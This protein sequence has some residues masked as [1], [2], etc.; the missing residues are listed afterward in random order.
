MAK[1]QAM[2]IQDSLLN[3]VRKEGTEVKIALIDG[4]SLMG[5]VRGFDNFTVVVQSKTNQHLLYKHAIAQII[6]RRPGARREEPEG[7][8][9]QANATP[10]PQAAEPKKPE[11]FNPIDLSGL[12]SDK[13]S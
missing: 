11:V 1:S 6:F 13:E 7:T 12:H 3:Q 8:Q 10:R 4:S 2:N 9:A 5:Q